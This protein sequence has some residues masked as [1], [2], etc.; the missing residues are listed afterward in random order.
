M[1]DRS[2]RRFTLG[3]E[4][5]LRIARNIEKVEKYPF[6]SLQTPIFL[7]PLAT[8][9]CTRARARI[10]SAFEDL[11]DLMLIFKIICGWF[12]LSGI[13]GFVVYCCSRVSEGHRPSEAPMPAVDED[14]EPSAEPN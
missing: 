1:G 4:D 10:Y 14:L 8:I 11:P 13:A 12:A 3:R 7:R 2:T 9:S 6:V 5:A